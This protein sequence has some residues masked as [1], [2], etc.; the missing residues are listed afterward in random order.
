MRL[1]ELLCQLT[2][3]VEYTSLDGKLPHSH[4]FAINKNGW[5][6]TTIIRG[7]GHEHIHKIEAFDIKPAGMD[8]HTHMLPADVIPQDTQASQEEQ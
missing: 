7:S 2:E 3:D 8:G 6:Q 1:E 5:G 4:K